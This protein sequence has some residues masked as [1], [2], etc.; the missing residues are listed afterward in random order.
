MNGRAPKISLTGSHVVDV[1]KENPKVLMESQDERISS[2]KTAKRIRTIKEE[3]R[4]RIPLKIRS[5][6]MRRRAYD[7][8][9]T[10]VIF[11]VGVWATIRE[12]TIAPPFKLKFLLHRNGG[13]LRFVQ[14]HKFRGK[15]RIK[16]GLRELLTIRHGPLQKFRQGPSLGRVLLGLIEDEVGESGDGIGA[17][18]RGVGHRDPDVFL[19]FLVQGGQGRRGAGR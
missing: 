15:G 19:K 8:V 3:K 13:D 17:L 14:P 5:P 2:E 10:S 11:V 4:T 9:S 12:S 6:S 7:S 16:K 1:T 18:A